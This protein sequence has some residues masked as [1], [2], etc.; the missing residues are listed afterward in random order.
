MSI[1]IILLIA[2][3]VYVLWFHPFKLE[4]GTEVKGWLAKHNADQS[5]TTTAGSAA[6]GN[7][8]PRYNSAPAQSPNE[9]PDNAP[10]DAEEAQGNEGLSC[11]AMGLDIN[12]ELK[13]F[14]RVFEIAKNDLFGEG[15]DAMEAIFGWLLIG[16]TRSDREI[17]KYNI[18]QLISDYYAKL[19]E[20]LNMYYTEQVKKGEST[21]EQLRTFPTLMANVHLLNG[22]IPFVHYGAR[23]FDDS[24]LEVINPRVGAWIDHYFDVNKSDMSMYEKPNAAELLVALYTVLNQEDDS[25]LPEN[26]EMFEDKYKFDFIM[27]K[28]A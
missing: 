18:W 5:S 26:K 17:N 7:I 13:D 23:Y 21:E 16:F 19:R 6:S 4:D 25:R 15:W 11:D 24:T 1:L 20:A 3:A 10:A 2:A 22:F 9:I 12:S 14:D 28:S 27:P 8:A